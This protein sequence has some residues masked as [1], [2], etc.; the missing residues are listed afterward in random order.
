MQAILGLV[1]LITFIV[2]YFFFPETS[3]PGARGIDKMKVE[4]GPDS[5]IPFMFINPLKPI[6]LLR[7]PSMLLVVRF[8]PSQCTGQRNSE[9]IKKGY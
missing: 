2:I 4:K 8:H 5:S 6:L 3:Q 9:S 1:G 7:S